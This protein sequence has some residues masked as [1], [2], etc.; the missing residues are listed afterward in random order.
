MSLAAGRDCWIFQVTGQIRNGD[1]VA[2]AGCLDPHRQN[3]GIGSG[4]FLGRKDTWDQSLQGLIENLPGI[5]AEDLLGRRVEQIDAAFSIGHHDGVEASLG[6]LA[7]PRLGLGECPVLELHLLSIPPL[8]RGEFTPGSLQCLALGDIAQDGQHSNLVIKLDRRGRDFH[9]ND[10]TVLGA[11]QTLAAQR[12]L[13]ELLPQPFLK[14]RGE[15]GD[16]NL[17]GRHSQQ[18]RARIAELPAC[19]GIGV[20]DPPFLI[21]HEDRV[22]DPIEQG[23]GAAFRLDQGGLGL[24]AFGDILKNAAQARDP[25]IH[26]A[27]LAL[28]NLNDQAASVPGQQDLL[29]R[30]QEPGAGQLLFEALAGGGPLRRRDDLQDGPARAALRCRNPKARKPFD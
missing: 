8:G 29:V 2:T 4:F 7:I 22:V 9:R 24:L 14:T 15:F 18:F 30:N 12:A 1:G 21:V 28:L 25:T 19:G 16:V 17:A 5:V 11:V 20:E 10:S 27:V 3:A 23:P 13:P 6:K 26:A